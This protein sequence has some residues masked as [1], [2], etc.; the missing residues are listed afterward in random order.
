MLAKKVFLHTASALLVTK[1]LIKFWLKKK[2]NRFTT[3]RIMPYGGFG[4][5]SKAVI[6]GRVLEGNELGS[7]RKEQSWRSNLRDMIRRF[8]TDEL[9]H[10]QL[11]ISYN[12]WQHIVTTDLEG[13]FYATIP[14]KN[15]LKPGWHSAT[16][17]LIEPLV[18]TPVRAEAKF[19]IAD[20]QAEYGI[21][22]DV[23]DTILQS[24]STSLIRMAKV[25][26]LNNAHTR[27]PLAGISAL[28][29]LLK[30]GS[31][32][33]RNNPFFYITG[34]AWNLY[35]LIIEFMKLNNIP[36]GPLHMRDL[37]LDKTRFLIGDFKHKLDKF[38]AILQT[39]PDLKFLLFGDSGE[40][41]PQLYVET[42]R[43]HPGRILA[44]YIRDTNTKKRS[45]TQ[46]YVQQARNLG[47]EMIVST[48]SDEA[49]R[50]AIEKGYI[51][52]SGLSAVK[53]DIRTDISLEQV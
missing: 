46:Q 38:S 27:K 3:I 39:Y 33:K 4:N 2:F 48:E 21:L 10:V 19:L 35:D 26:F 25:T 16:V 31:D 40:H 13:Y 53:Q 36:A 45:R 51:P 43:R 12:S 9:P 14:L 37:G 50:H 18:S 29:Q 30:K 28:F 24:Y 52:A 23:D 5:E 17:E 41:D 34:S 49:A 32:G 7:P 11:R 8:R 6:Q 15:K 22:S 44:V 42:I 1:K 47:V 20:P